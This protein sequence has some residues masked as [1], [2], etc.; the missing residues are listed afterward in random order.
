MLALDRRDQSG[1][2]VGMKGRVMF[3]SQR[4][5]TFN[6]AAITAA[7]LA[8]AGSLAVAHA[9]PAGAATA[10]A[11]PFTECP[12]IGASPSCEILLV[13]NAD[14]TVSVD[15]DP[16]VG[17]FDGSDDTLVGIINNSTAPVKAVTV[18]G[19]GSGLSQFDGDGICSG[20]YGTWNGSSG[21]PYGPT[22]YEGPGT[23][24]TTD[25]SLP[26][27]AEV[28]FTGGLSPGKSAYFSLEGALTSAELTAREGGLSAFTIS[29]SD[30][31][32]TGEAGKQAT[33]SAA[34][35]KVCK[36]WLGQIKYKSAESLG[37][38][39]VNSEQALGLTTASEFLAY[40]LAGTGAPLNL[41]AT[42]P[43]AAEI[44]KSTEFQN[45]NT[46]V[47]NYIRQQLE[48]GATNI[49]LPVPNPLHAFAFLNYIKEPDLY[50]AF[51]RTNGVT[52]SGSG[53][54]AGSDYTGTLTYVIRESYGFSAANTL[55]DF[56]PPMRYLQTTC[57]A[58]YYPGGA[59]WFPVTVT[60]TEP[61]DLPR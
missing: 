26:D 35:A 32:T 57:G 21:C 12:A 2:R 9:V 28:D 40:F 18:S 39:T 25:P 30:Q 43:V 34:D 22:G 55:L 59:H 58:P 37:K 10:P 36:S 29:G 46:S 19:P 38:R 60:I 23:S 56:G 6:I 42:S 51:R 14:N 54:I 24:F 52:V 49:Q 33:G 41:P 5:Q 20:D 7:A 50:L 48:A 11:P 61:F 53:S 31:S 44:Q 47:L 16:S 27:S 45:E 17:P 1:T 4:K 15:G 13:V 3:K 8:A